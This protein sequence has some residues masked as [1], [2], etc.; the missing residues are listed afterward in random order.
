S[1]IFLNAANLFFQNF[2][3]NDP[4]FYKNLCLVAMN[5]WKLTNKPDGAKQMFEK[6][7]SQMKQYQPNYEKVFIFRTYGEMLLEENNRS[8]LG[9][10]LIDEANKM[11]EKLPYFECRKIYLTL[12][13]ES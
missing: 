4:L 10:N 13:S 6:V 7:I 1:L 11:E 5:N 3:N 2:S 9:N 8:V 12:P